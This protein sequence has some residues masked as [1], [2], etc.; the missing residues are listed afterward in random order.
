MESGM[1]TS[2]TASIRVVCIWENRSLAADFKRIS[3]SQDRNIGVATPASIPMIA[4]TVSISTS[5]NP[6]CER[7]WRSK[8]GAESV[9]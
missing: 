7:R 5:D 6:D 2:F 8:K 9:C 1:T 3:G 4:M